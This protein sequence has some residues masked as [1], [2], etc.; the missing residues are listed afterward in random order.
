MDLCLIL[1][2]TLPTNENEWYLEKEFASELTAALY[3]ALDS[4]H[5]GAV[6]FGETTAL[7][8]PLQ[9]VENITEVRKEIESFSGSLFPWT[10]LLANAIYKTK[11]NCFSKNEDRPGVAN[12][13]IIAS[14]TKPSSI[15]FNDYIKA[16]DLLRKSKGGTSMIAVGAN[17]SL[18]IEFLKHISSGGN[19]FKA[20]S[21]SEVS[22][23]IQPI[24]KHALDIAAGK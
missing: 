12:L 6:V 15:I 16:A 20:A 1:E 23:F 21:F 4:L 10:Y 3:Y 17:N 8:L 19:Y 11:D 9:K 14:R 18:D 13:A 24:V 7:T 2:N 22:Q 5:V